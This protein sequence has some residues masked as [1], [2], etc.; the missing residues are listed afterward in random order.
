MNLR[1]WYRRIIQRLI[2]PSYRLVSRVLNRLLLGKWQ[3]LTAAA[4]VSQVEASGQVKVLTVWNSYAGVYRPVTGFVES[5]ETPDQAALRELAEETP[6]QGEIDKIIGIYKVGKK[7]QQLLVAYSVKNLKIQSQLSSHDQF[8][9]QELAFLIESE[10]DP[11]FKM[12][13]H[14]YGQILASQKSEKIP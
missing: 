14:D 8:Q 9:W 13:Y 5:G 2:L 7:V 1:D 3:V 12:L 4:L 6:Y 10:L 11:A